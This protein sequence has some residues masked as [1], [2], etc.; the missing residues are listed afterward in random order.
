LSAGTIAALVLLIA[1]VVATLRLPAIWRNQI[2]DQ[3]RTQPWWPYG[4]KAW[5][6][7][8]RAMPLGIAAAWLIC[9]VVLL[10][11][12]LPQRPPDSLVWAVPLTTALALVL[13]FMVTTWC[14][15]W[16]KFLVPPHL[17]NDPGALSNLGAR[18]ESKAPDTRTRR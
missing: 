13:F 2:K 10:G 7:F 12:V 16:P 17:R 8:L 4:D 11:Q 3:D 6:G 15:N 18:R 14:W 9:A 5:R 1:A